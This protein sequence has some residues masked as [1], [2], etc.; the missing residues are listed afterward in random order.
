MMA[1]KWPAGTE[2]HEIILAVE[3]SQCEA[4]G[5]PLNYRSNRTRCV[6]SFQGPLRLACHL[7]CCFNPRCSQYEVLVSPEAERLVAMPYW[8][9]GWD[10]L[11]WMGFRR[12]ARHWSVPQI[13]AELLD[14]YHIRFTIEMLS[15]DLRK[16]QVMVAARHQDLRRLRTLYHGYPNVILTIDG[17]QPEKGHETLYVVRELRLQ[18]VWFA[19][20]LL[21]SSAAEIR[22]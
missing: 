10:I 1:A 16:Y 14:S 5:W 13:Q 6:Q 19:E 8:R 17:V 7:F 22:K 3:A 2:F 18:R 15:N 11:L 21:S 12:Y 20:P 4:C 9:M